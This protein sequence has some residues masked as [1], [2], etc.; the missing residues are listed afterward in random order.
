MFQGAGGVAAIA[1]AGGGIAEL[2]AGSK[3]HKPLPHIPSF[4]VKPAGREASFR[5]QPDLRPPTVTTTAMQTAERLGRD[6]PRSLFLGPG[7]V[8]LSAKRF[9]SIGP[10]A[11]SP[12]CAPPAAGRWTSTL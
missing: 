11:R 10:I 1:I 2:L 12:A 8:T 7:P 5:S 6:D 9:C 4:A 3:P